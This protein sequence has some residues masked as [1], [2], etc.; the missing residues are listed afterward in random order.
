MEDS[1]AASA[2]CLQHQKKNGQ[3][4]PT[5]LQVP[6]KGPKPLWHHGCVDDGRS[7]EGRE[8][9]KTRMASGGRR[10][11]P[12]ILLAWHLAHVEGYGGTEYE[13]PG[14]LKAESLHQMMRKTF[15]NIDYVHERDP[16]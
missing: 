4:R 2:Y 12:R 14:E 5:R 13:V 16:G 1:N 7:F 11:V 10:A 15:P 3:P 6:V 8:C 9:G